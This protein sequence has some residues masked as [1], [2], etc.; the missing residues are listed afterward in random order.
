MYFH[1]WAGYD[2]I[3]SLL[4][5][6]G[7]EEHGFTFTPIV[8]HGQVLSLTVFQRVKSKNRTV[9][10]IKDSLKIIPGAL[11]KLAKDF[12]VPTQKDHFPHYFLVEGDVGK[13]LNYVG[14]LPEYPY[15]EPKRTS[16][17]DY[18]EMLE[19]FKTKP[20]SFLEVS[21]EYIKG[22]VLAQYQIIVKFFSELR[23]KFPINPMDL[24]SAP[25]TAFKIWKTV[26]LPLLNEDKFK[27]YDLSRSL[28]PKFRG[29][30]LGGIVDVYR[31][32]LIG[33]GY[34]YD[35]NSLYP[36]AMCRPMPVGIPAPTK[37]TLDEFQASDFFGYLQATVQ[38]PPNEYIGLLPIRLGGRLVCPGGKISGFFFSEE[39]RFALEHGYRL[40][41]IEEAWAFQ[42]GDNTFKVLI[43]KLN[44]MKV[45]AQL[46][47]KPVLRNISK[48][49]MNSMYGRFGMHTPELKHA[50]VKPQQL[51]NILENYLVLE[52]ITLGTLELITYILNKDLLDFSKDKDMII[53]RKYLKGIPGNTNVAI[54]AAVTAYSRMIINQYK[55]DALALGLNIYYS[56]TD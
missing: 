26:Q 27:V 43:D 24:L 37:L 9:L 39:L 34:Y 17:A 3:L 52:K 50:I 25:G 30:Y 8:Q 32:H 12:R 16:K 40:L 46:E 45:N 54:A 11:A 4:P 42:R 49:L 36:A 23:S 55:L 2:S 6:L 29:A 15:F 28:D 18:D 5:L 44:L 10:T 20:W 56:D 47:G 1:N 31:P 13:T 14:T 41:G 19:V 22:D 21:R 7:L 53:L 48:L 38:S 33:Q 35:V 51:D